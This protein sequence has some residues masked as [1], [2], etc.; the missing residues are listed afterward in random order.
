MSDHNY[1]DDYRKFVERCN[2]MNDKGELPPV[3]EPKCG[4]C[5]ITLGNKMYYVCRHA[6]CPAELN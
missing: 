4:K 2:R 1:A 5:G 3:S 6:H